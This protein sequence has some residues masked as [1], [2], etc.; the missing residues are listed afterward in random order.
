MQLTFVSSWPMT[1][2]FQLF[3]NQVATCWKILRFFK[4]ATLQCN[5]IVSINYSISVCIEMTLEYIKIGLHFITYF[6]EIKV[7]QTEDFMGHL[8][9]PGRSLPTH[10][11]YG[12]DVSLMSVCAFN[13]YRSDEAEN[14]DLAA[15][16]GCSGSH[17]KKRR[18]KQPGSKCRLVVFLPPRAL[19]SFRLIFLKGPVTG[20]SPLKRISIVVAVSRCTG[21]LRAAFWKSRTNGAA[22]WLS[23]T[24][25]ICSHIFKAAP[26][27]T[28]AHNPPQSLII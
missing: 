5:N 6:L 20:A 17:E 25:N 22:H 7:W 26:P 16:F 19:L 12:S 2:D 15:P 23:R 21:M 18:W 28:T 14:F 11:L 3:H 24:S 13:R 10:G 27:P 4:F 1:P 9:P 8:W